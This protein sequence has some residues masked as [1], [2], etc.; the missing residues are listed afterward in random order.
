[1]HTCIRIA[2]H[3]GSKWFDGLFVFTCSCDAAMHARSKF[4]SIR[5]GRA[6]EADLERRYLKNAFEPLTKIT[7]K[8]ASLERT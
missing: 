5:R 8:T 4:D 3:D 7:N 1:M 2:H 6:L